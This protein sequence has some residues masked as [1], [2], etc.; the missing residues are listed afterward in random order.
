MITDIDTTLGRTTCEVLS[1]DGVPLT[2]FIA[3]K[4]VEGNGARYVDGSLKC[5]GVVGSAPL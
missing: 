5:V 2:V 1:G 4:V 3:F